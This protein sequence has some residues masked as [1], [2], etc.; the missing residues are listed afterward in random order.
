MIAKLRRRLTY[1]NV[2]ATVAVFIALGG[3]AVASIPGPGGVIK[4]CYSKSTGTLRVIDS[5]KSCSKKRERTLRWNQQG[6]RGLQG[7]PGAQG[8]QGSQ[9]IQ[10][11]NGATN[12]VIRFPSVF[13][14]GN[15]VIQCS[16]SGG[17]RAVGGGGLVNVTTNHLTQS[18]PVASGGVPVDGATSTGWLAAADTSAGVTA[19]AKAF[20][21]CASP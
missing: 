12:V 13:T 16:A 14:T 10:G 1:G 6:V 8:I 17:E 3:V 2:M 20:V 7:I 11:P 4:A 19:P 21:V 5:K 9:G 15:S 18:A